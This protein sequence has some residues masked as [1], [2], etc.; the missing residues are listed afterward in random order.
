MGLGV[1]PVGGKVGCDAVN[2]G[3][4]PEDEIYI[5]R[6]R[7]ISHRDFPY[8][9]AIKETEAQPTVQMQNME[10]HGESLNAS[11]R[12]AEF[13]PES[14]KAAARKRLLLF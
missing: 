6:C 10:I 2:L 12:R 4:Q 1:G 3:F 14:K 7:S 11:C 5:A 8:R 9:N 13:P